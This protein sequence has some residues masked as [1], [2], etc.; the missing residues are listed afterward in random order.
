[1]SG[2]ESANETTYP[3]ITPYLTIKDAAAAIAFYEKVF[4][5]Q[6]A[7]R[8]NWPDSDVVC[9]AT[10]IIQGAPVML[11]EDMPKFNGGKP[12]DP[13]GLGG[14][15]VS[16]HLHLPTVADADALWARAIEAGCPVLMPIGP[17]FWGDHFGMFADPFG[18][19]WS[20][21]ATVTKPTL[22]EMEASLRGF[23]SNPEG[24]GVKE[25]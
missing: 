20:L 11:T 22:A 23:M 12:G 25:G 4:D 6:V 14:T 19:R 24:C 3:P 13:K 2:N 10:L 9:H 8:L 7:M 18:H 5:A 17:Q 21:G 16:V 1:M 15:P